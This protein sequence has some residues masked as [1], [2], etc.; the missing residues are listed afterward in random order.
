MLLRLFRPSRAWIPRYA[1]LPTPRRFSSAEPRPL[2][3]AQLDLKPRMRIHFTCTAN[4]SSSSQTCQHANTHEFS[5]HAY[6]RGIVLVECPSCKNRHLIGMYL[7]HQSRCVLEELCLILGLD[8]Y[9]ADH[10]Q[11]FTNNST[12]DDP[13]FSGNHRNIV[14]LMRAKGEKVKR[15]RTGPDE[16]E[17]LEFYDDEKHQ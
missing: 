13:N 5:K 14:D 11:W 10:L 4:T 2:P 9:I 7:S 6:E 15:G 8:P 17:V 16:G 3:S 1:P 12:A